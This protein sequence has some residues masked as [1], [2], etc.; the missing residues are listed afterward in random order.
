[1]WYVLRTIKGREFEACDICS[2]TF[3]MECQADVFVP[4]FLKPYHRNGE[5]SEVRKVLF[6]GYIFV[7]TDKAGAEIIKDIVR[8]HIS[9]KAE[10]I[11]SNADFV[12][13][14]NEEQKFIESLMDKEHVVRI[15]TGNV[16][17]GKVVVDDGPL[18]PY[19]D[20]VCWYD[21]HKRMARV[22][23]SLMGQ[24]KSILVGLALENRIYTKAG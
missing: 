6:P 13:I 2:K 22:E 18:A 24:T 14:Y 16:V 20:K 17:D 8:R 1:M 4:C 3:L 19:A 15:S 21:R 12:P 11:C 9:L 10:V 7:D 23:M 5:W